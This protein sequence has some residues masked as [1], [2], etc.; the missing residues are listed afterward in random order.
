MSWYAA[1]LI[2]VFRV[3]K[4]KQERFPVWENVYLLESQSAEDAWRKAEEFGRTEQVDDESLT[5]DDE[6]AFLRFS[7]VRKVVAIQNPFPTTPNADP[8]SDKTEIT[9][10]EFTLNSEEDVKRLVAGEC[11]ALV[12]EDDNSR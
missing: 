3:Q 7:G 8:P 4:G 6:P 5:L 1:S 9:Y 10:S 2:F 11:V 12:Y